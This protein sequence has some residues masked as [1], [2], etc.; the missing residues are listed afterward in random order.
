[1]QGKGLSHACGDKHA[2]TGLSRVAEC[3]TM[4]ANAR[5]RS[6]VVHAR[7]HAAAGS[8]QRE[9]ERTMQQPLEISFKNLDRSEV[10]EADIGTRVDKLEQLFDGIT[11]CHVHIEAPHR[12]HR[13]GN[14]YEVRLEVRVPGTELVVAN[15]PGDVNAH[16][17]AHVAIRD[18]FNAMER[19]L[20]KWKRQIRHE[21]RGHAAPLQGRISELHAEDGFGAIATTDHRLVYFHANSVVGGRFEDLAEGDT[22]ELVVRSGESPQGPQASTVRP[23]SALDYV[24]DPKRAG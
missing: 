6:C 3:G 8:P 24:D 14:R 19:Q 4:V 9:R 22:V 18:A 17:D 23:I 15:Q 12:H 13:K 5:R 16:E 2:R 21:P 20:K 11:S 7:P 10:L 1:V